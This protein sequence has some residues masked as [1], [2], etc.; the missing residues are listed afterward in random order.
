MFSDFDFYF[1]RVKG[2][3]M[4]DSATK[5]FPSVP[6]RMWLRAAFTVVF[7][8]IVCFIVWEAGLVPR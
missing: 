1:R 3:S 8:I 7:I 2:E 4:R 6:L 5:D